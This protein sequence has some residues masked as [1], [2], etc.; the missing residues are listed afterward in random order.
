MSKAFRMYLLHPDDDL[1]C[2]GSARASA[3]HGRSGQDVSFASGRGHGSPLGMPPFALI[4][5]GAGSR[6]D[7]AATMRCGVM[8][9]G[10]GGAVALDT[11]R[12]TWHGR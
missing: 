8:A 12:E 1:S 11:P 7:G 2:S 4:P 6:R 3:Q 9:C 10:R 5:R